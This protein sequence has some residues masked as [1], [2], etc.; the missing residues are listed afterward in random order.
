MKR[1]ASANNYRKLI[2]QASTPKGRKDWATYHGVPV[3]GIATPRPPWERDAPM[4]SARQGFEGLGDSM[5][6]LESAL[7]EA[8]RLNEKLLELAPHPMQEEV[9]SNLRQ[10]KILMNRI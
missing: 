10:M 1:I 7:D 4:P 8:L 5:I 2:R 3:E 6:V 9:V